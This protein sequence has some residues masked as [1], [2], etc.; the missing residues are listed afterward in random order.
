M[1]TV[2]KWGVMTKLPDLRVESI[3]LPVSDLGVSRAWFASVFDLHE[4]MEWADDDGVVRGVA[5][6]GI[7]QLLLA[8]REEPGAAAA[9]RGFGFL[10]IGV[11]AEADLAACATHLES[12]GIP[13]TKVITGAQGRLVGFHDPDGR[14]LSFYAVTDRGGVRDD[15]MRPVRAVPPTP[16]EPT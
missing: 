5:M 12:L 3:K 8:L 11:P 7:G 10:N 15:A 14:E 2:T 9:T 13:H 1:I 4:T 16:P 6:A